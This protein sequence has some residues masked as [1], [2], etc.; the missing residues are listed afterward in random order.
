MKTRTVN[1]REEII[2][3]MK[4]AKRKLQ[5]AVSWLTD[6]LIISEMIEISKRVKIELLLSNDILNVYRYNEIRQLQNNGASVNKTGSDFPGISG[7]MHLKLMIIDEETVYGGSYNFTAAANENNENFDQYPWDRKDYYLEKFSELMKKAKDYQIGFENPE[8]IKEKIAEK[9]A[10]DE[11][12]R[13]ELIRTTGNNYEKQKECMASERE[14]IIKQ[15]IKKENLRQSARQIQNGESKINRNGD[16]SASEGIKSKPHRFYGGKLI[17][18]FIGAKARNS[19][20][21]AF[22]Q[23]KSLGKKFDSF[24]CHI[25]NDTLIAV[26]IIKLNN[27]QPYKIRIEARAGIPPQVY[28]LNHDILPHPDI[29]MY[30]NRSLCLYYPGDLRWKDNLQ[31]AETMIPWVYEWILFY[32]LYNLSG[33]WEGAYVP[34]QQISRPLQADSKRVNN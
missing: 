15:E 26:G 30:D 25:D 24:K 20:S 27:C 3:L 17:T 21:Y 16:L 13:A 18:T 19:Y 31:I 22:Y 5:I 2:N 6:E 29:H 9:F 4:A 10:L 14:N 7:F 8:I 32:E 12:F 33:I 28:I 34:H 1:K 11:K 23:K